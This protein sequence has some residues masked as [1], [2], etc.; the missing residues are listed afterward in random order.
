ML[1]I[2]TAKVRKLIGVRRMKKWIQPGGTVD[3]DSYDA[4]TLG[5]NAGFFILYKPE[6][7]EKVEATSPKETKD[8]D[9][10]NQGA[11]ADKDGDKIR[12]TGS[13]KEVKAEKEAAKKQESEDRK[14][15]K[16]SLE[17]MTKARLI[18]VA[19]SVV[20]IDVKPKDN[21]AKILKKILK[22]SKDKGYAYVL[23]NS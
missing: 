16:E 15:L 17:G 8:E 12:T 13:E 10:N 23:K 2:N 1:Y 9:A 7:K 5:G 11:P 14:A 19:E 22:A 18:E 21:K 20:K 3:L 4:R 6:P